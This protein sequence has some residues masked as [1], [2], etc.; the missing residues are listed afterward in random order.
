MDVNFYNTGGYYYS[1]SNSRSAADTQ[2]YA[3][4]GRKWVMNITAAQMA[5]VAGN[6]EKATVRMY[7][8]QYYNST[9]KFYA[10]ASKKSGVTDAFTDGNYFGKT[11][12]QSCVLYPQWSEYNFDVTTCFKYAQENWPG[13]AW[14]LW[15]YWTEGSSDGTALLGY[16]NTSYADWRKPYFTITL[17]GGGEL[18]TPY[19]W[20]TERTSIRVPAK[21]MT[22]ATSQSCTASAS[23]TYSSSYP[24]WRCYD[25]STTTAAWASSASASGPWVKLNMNKKLYDITVRIYNRSDRDDNIRGP[26]AGYIEASNDDSTWVDIGEF[27][28]RNGSTKGH[29]TEHVCNNS[30]VAYK[31]VRV[32]VTNWYPSSN[33]TY[34]AIGELSINGY[35]HPSTGHWAKATPYRV[36][37]SG[38]FVKFTNSY[39]MESVE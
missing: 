21:A 13:E 20:T 36:D 30:T 24:A 37:D 2:Y 34:C 8:Q 7:N 11:S 18:A 10:V 23:S 14:Y 16:N 33:K 26:I 6:V 29:V 27:S 31:Y 22:A 19:V 28:G 35:E 25:Y 3:S 5:L 39:V 1:S 32:R 17:S 38:T 9:F 12:T 4:K 15:F